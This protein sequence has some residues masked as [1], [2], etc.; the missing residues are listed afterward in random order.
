MKKK[1]IIAIVVLALI[2][3]VVVMMFQKPKDAREVYSIG[4]LT[5]NA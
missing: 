5:P 1:N 2:T 4:S 3:I